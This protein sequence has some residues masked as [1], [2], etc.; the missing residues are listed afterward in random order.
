MPPLTRR[1]RDPAQRWLPEGECTAACSGH[2]TAHC[3]L[4]ACRASERGS[5]AKTRQIIDGYFTGRA[6]DGAEAASHG[7]SHQLPPP[8][9]VCPRMCSSRGRDMTVRCRRRRRRRRR[10]VECLTGF[11]WQALAS[12]AASCRLC[13]A[14]SGSA[15]PLRTWRSSSTTSR[16]CVQPG[17]PSTSGPPSLACPALSVWGGGAGSARTPAR[18]GAHDMHHPDGGGAEIRAPAVLICAQGGATLPRA[19]FDEIFPLPPQ[20]CTAN[21]PRMALMMRRARHLKATAPQ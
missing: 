9:C 4:R 17:R 21:A 11:L 6:A 19:A 15:S 13:S 12:R 8:P 1:A 14:S 20:V 16:R 18:G 7:K 3:R 5:G 10:R 2:A